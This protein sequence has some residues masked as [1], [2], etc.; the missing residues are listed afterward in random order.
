MRRQPRRAVLKSAVG[1]TVAG[2]AGCSEQSDSE[3]GPSEND[4]DGSATNDSSDDTGSDDQFADDSTDQ[5][6]GADESDGTDSTESESVDVT[7]PDILYTNWFPA[8]SDG[9][10]VDSLQFQFF[11]SGHLRSVAD[12]LPSTIQGNYGESG[13]NIVPEGT[14]PVD[15]QLLLNPLGQDASQYLTRP[16]YVYGGDFDKPALETAVEDDADFYRNSY[17]NRTMYGDFTVY[18]YDA[19][20]DYQAMTVGI[21]DDYFFQRSRSSSLEGIDVT[22]RIINASVGSLERVQD[23]STTVARMYDLLDGGT[24]VNVS[25]DDDTLAADDPKTG[26]GLAYSLAED[27][28]KLRW[29]FAFPD[30]DSV[31][32]NQLDGIETQLQED[33]FSDISRTEEG[34]VIRVA[35]SKP[36][37]DLD[38][39]QTLY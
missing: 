14:G 11:D 17:A 35:G 22:K 6:D 24:I 37:A 34:P 36:T 33:G 20:G 27:T 13:Y 38:R 39:I 28:T 30:P 8:P 25:F 26:I 29:V 31:A 3:E 19:T 10:A 32:S 4:A 1:V 7:L 18:A 16:L 21:S 2:L 23:R 9:A 12:A 5:S 15:S